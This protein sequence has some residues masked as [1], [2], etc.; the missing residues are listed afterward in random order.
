[1]KVIGIDASTIVKSELSFGAL[2]VL[3]FRFIVTL[4]SRT[5]SGEISNDFAKVELGLEVGAISTGT[6]PALLV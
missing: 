6:S 4:S 1:M 5:Y 3:Y 2:A